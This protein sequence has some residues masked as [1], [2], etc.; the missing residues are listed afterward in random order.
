MTPLQIALAA[1]AALA[2]LL[3]ALDPRRPALL[4]R[5][6]RMALLLILAALF[7]APF[8][9]IACASFKDSRALM[10]YTFLPPPVDWG[11]MLTLANFRKLFEPRVSLQGTVVFWQYIL[12]SLFLASTATVIQ[13]FFC[14]LGGYALAK[15]RFTG[16][17]NLM[18]FMAGSLMLPSMLF[19]APTYDML[20]HIGW[21]DSYAALLV[22][23]AANAFG[24]FLFRQAMLSVPDSLIEAARVDGASEFR[25]Y[26][27]IV[28]PLVQ[29]MTAAFCLIVFM[30]QW[31]SF[32]NPQI[33]IQSDY[34]LT[35][36]V[37]LS[38]YVSQ[39]QEEYG[40]FLA[41]TFLSIIP[42]AI[43][44]L[45]LQKEF[46]SELTGGARRG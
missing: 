32:L 15:F 33:Y 24:I 31:N 22:P 40:M 37:I 23:S 45:T 1:A 20:V 11:S 25:I 46:I 2:A 42:I 10:E 21:I 34:K 17:R 5:Y 9:W 19:L 36:P 29:P 14:S 26:A 39:F 41:G 30:G 16:R 3:Y 44:F 4:V 38:Q 8:A 7:L 6:G 18:L 12:N 28:M 27:R 35:V 43:L 13:V